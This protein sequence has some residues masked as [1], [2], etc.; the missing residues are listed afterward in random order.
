[1]REKGYNTAMG[2][3]SVLMVI[4]QKKFRDE[5]LEHPLAVFRE[6]GF[7]VTVAAREKMEAVGMFGAKVMPDVTVSEAAAMSFDALV[8]VGGGGS[9]EY[10]WGDPTLLAMARAQHAAN[11]PVAAICLAPVVLAQAGLLTGV[12]AT[13][14]KSPDSVAQ[15]TKHGV[16]MVEREVV[17]SGIIVTANGPASA[18]KFGL[19]VAELLR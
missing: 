11:R 5:E 3:K 16:K 13:V 19:A 12:E 15:F 17:T 10:L 14:Y 9:P 18:R 1:M 2:K 7:S 6:K 4:S 8:F